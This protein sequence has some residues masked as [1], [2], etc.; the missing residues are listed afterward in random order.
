[1]MVHTHSQ[2][3]GL[4][5]DVLY[6]PVSGEMLSEGQT[7]MEGIDSQIVSMHTSSPHL[8]VLLRYY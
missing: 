5:Y 6:I 1:M 3:W 8:T 4:G 7:L 2:R